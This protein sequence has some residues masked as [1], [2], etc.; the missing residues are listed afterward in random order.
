MEPRRT[1][2]YEALDHRL[3]EMNV[4]VKGILNKL[5]DLSHCVDELDRRVNRFPLFFDVHDCATIFGRSTRTIKRWMDSGELKSVMING[6]MYVSEFELCSFLSD[7]VG[8]KVNPA[9]IRSEIEETECVSGYL[10]QETN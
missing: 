2:D 6:V 3:S 10:G 9:Q 1:D 5:G 7:K 8:E 4:S